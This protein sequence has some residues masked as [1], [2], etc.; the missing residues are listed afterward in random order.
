MIILEPNV[1]S[2]EETQCAC[3]QVFLWQWKGV[4]AHFH[5]FWILAASTN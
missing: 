4:L 3:A 2:G 5:S 1:F